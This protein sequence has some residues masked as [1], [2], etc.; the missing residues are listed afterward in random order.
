M[1]VGRAFYDLFESPEILGPDLCPFHTAIGRGQPACS[2]LKLDEKRFSDV[3][4]TPLL[5][6]ETNWGS[7]EVLALVALVRDVSSQ[8]KKQEN[9]HAIH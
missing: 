3:H 6:G 4:V 9:L 8:V 7:G 5:D 1:P 2:M